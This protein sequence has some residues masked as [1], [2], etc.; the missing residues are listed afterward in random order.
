MEI[1]KLT[2]GYSGADLRELSTEASMMPIRKLEGSIENIQ[3]DSVPAA[4]LSD[5]KEALRFVRPT[6]NR[7]QL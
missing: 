3:S 7:A 4:N 2:K 6:V 1:T 5:L